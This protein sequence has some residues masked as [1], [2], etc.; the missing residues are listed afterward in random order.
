MIFHL[1]FYLFWILLFFHLSHFR[2]FLGIIEMVLCKNAL[3]GLDY[4]HDVVE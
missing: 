1:K 4:L 3:C 2:L